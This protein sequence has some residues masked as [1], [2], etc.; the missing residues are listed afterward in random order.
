[1]AD[2]TIYVPGKKIKEEMLEILRKRDVYP[3]VS[4]YVVEGL[5]QTSLRG[6]DSHGISLFPH[7]VRALEAGRING[8]PRFLFRQTS[9]AAGKL[10]ADHTF[11]HAAGMEAM[12][13]ATEMASRAGVAAVAVSHSSHFGAAAYY[14]LFAAEKNM[15]G[16]SFTHA[17]SLL[18]TYAGKKPYFG[19]NPICLAAPCAGEGPF[20]LDMA[21]TIV[22]WNKIKKW[23]EKGNDIPLDIAADKNGKMTTVGSQVASLL[24]IGGYKGFGLSMMIDVLCG[25]LTGMPFGKDIVSMYKAPVSTRRNLGHFFIAI[26]IAAFIP[27]GVFKRRM[28]EMMEDVRRQPSL[29]KNHPVMVAGDPEK[30][31][32]ALRTKKGIPFS[33]SEYEKIRALRE[34]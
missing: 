26:N 2:K 17:D 10:D 20:C 24:P 27:V 14:S 23:R 8:R 22:N 33:V 12:K 31:T 16:L 25:L 19:T 7:Y 6:V 4:R 5:V 13:R 21:T 15:I 28:K 11:G 9:A 32:Y 18:L 1:M 34:T 29:R 3:E 30:R